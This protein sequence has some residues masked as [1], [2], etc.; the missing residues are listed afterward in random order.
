MSSLFP[1]DFTKAGEQRMINVRSV[2]GPN[3]QE[4][5]VVGEITSSQKWFGLVVHTITS[6]F[7]QLSDRLCNIGA[8]DSPWR[9]TKKEQRE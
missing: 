6:V 1:A 8:T 4:S 9:T 7:P 5:K 2:G 3:V